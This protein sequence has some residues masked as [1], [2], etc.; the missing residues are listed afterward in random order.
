MVKVFLL[1]RP[2]SGKTTAF[3]YI[4][5]CAHEKDIRS[6]R[7]REYE[8]LRGMFLAGRSEFRKAKHGGFD[9]LDF[10][11]VNESAY[12]LEKKIQS[13]ARF[14]AQENE[15]LFIELVRD[16][17]EQAMHCFSSAFL[18]DSYFLFIEA[19]L[20]TCIQRIHYRVAH[21]AG[22]DGH[23]VSDHIL[24]NYYAYD[25]KDYM[26]TRFRTDYNIQKMVEV[27]ENTGSPDEFRKKLKPFTDVLLPEKVASVPSL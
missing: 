26:A 19:D 25:N 18:Q 14:E 9:I 11:V 7:F 12:L 16:S 5:T 23:F 17:Y 8:I 20:E 1:G 2:G 24:R 10:S 4:E 3:H 27:I 13:Y 15:L 6:T 22:T 21:P